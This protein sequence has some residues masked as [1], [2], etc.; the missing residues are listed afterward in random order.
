MIL[1]RLLAVV[2]AFAVAGCEKAPP[3]IVIVSAEP[4]APVLAAECTDADPAWLELP[5]ADVRRAEA[6]RNY[7]LNK[8]RY[9][10]LLAKRRVC[11]AALAAQF[12][13]PP[14]EE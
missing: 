5:D 9:R 4:A 13:P 2:L 6:A 8:G 3:E 11:R 10:T 14:A 12:P 1:S 7:R